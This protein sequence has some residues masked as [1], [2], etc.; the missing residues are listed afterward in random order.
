MKRLIAAWLAMVTL[1]SLALPGMAEEENALQKVLQGEIEFYLTDAYT[2]EEKAALLPRDGHWDFLGSPEWN[3]FFSRYA[4]LDLDGDGT[5]EAAL[6]V[7]QR[8]EEDIYPSGYLI[9]REHEGAVQGYEMY[10]RSMN[11][12]KA[13]GSFSY[14]SGAMDSGFAFLR[15]ENGL[16]VPEPFTW[17]E[18]GEDMETVYFYVDGQPAAEEDFSQAVLKQNAKP[19][20]DWMPF[21]ATAEG[22]ATRDG[23][24]VSF[25]YPAYCRMEYE[26]RIGTVVHLSDTDYV[27][28]VVTEKGVSGV[29]NL[30]ENI[31]NQDVIFSLSDDAH[32]FA[33]HGDEHHT[34]FFIRHQDV[35][36][37]GLNLPDGTGVIVNSFCEYGHTEIY[38]VLLTIFGS[39]TD[40]APLEAWLNEVWLPHVS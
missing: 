11:E 18:S 2:G 39:L 30:H 13:D 9:L 1:L 21:P 31:A 34:S 26:D 7:S 19:E 8:W 25:R 15:F 17:C 35:V 32:V 37:I 10:I 28:V 24:R 5:T 4:L 40:S 23:Q 33:S 27:A 6:E 29:E 16:P 14:S 3:A 12:L 20:P 22:Y 38:D 36:E